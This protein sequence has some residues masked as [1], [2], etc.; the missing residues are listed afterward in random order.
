M[1]IPRRDSNASAGGDLRPAPAEESNENDT[2]KSPDLR[3]TNYGTSN[4]TTADEERRGDDEDYP[5][6]GFHAW[7]VVFGAWCCMIGG[8]ALLN[9]QA[10][11]QSYIARNQLSHY[12]EST[13]GWIFSI[14]LFVVFFLGIQVGPLFDALG[15]RILIGV[16][17]ICLTMSLI[18]LGE[19]T[20]YWHFILVYGVLGGLGN[21]LIFTTSVAAVGHYFLTRRGT[22]TGVACCG[23]ALGGV[24]FPLMLQSLFPQVGW[25]WRCIGSV[26]CSFA[27]A[28]HSYMEGADVVTLENSEM[29]CS[30]E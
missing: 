13:V 30:I 5:E 18:L 21:A 24:I 9:S 26:T 7:V 23:G 6:G 17:T 4:H 29:V 11:L 12:S 15:P 20:K 19:C 10:P 16:G 22:A 8:L 1:S 14:Q 2:L 25:G 27:N 28:V 3:T